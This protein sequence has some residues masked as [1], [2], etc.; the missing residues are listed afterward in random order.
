M[1]APSVVY[2]EIDGTFWLTW[3]SENTRIDVTIVG[4]DEVRE[5]IRSLIEAAE[6]EHA[7]H[8]KPIPGKS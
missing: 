2:D 1:L 8:H 4:R 3:R 7:T 6:S 5:L